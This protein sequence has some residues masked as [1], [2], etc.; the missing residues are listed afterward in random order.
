M[1]EVRSRLAGQPFSQSLHKLFEERRGAHAL[2]SRVM[3]FLSISRGGMDQR[4]E[5]DDQ[6]FNSNSGKDVGKACSKSAFDFAH[7]P[8]FGSARSR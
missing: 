2:P 6:G 1:E 4:A 5:L 7:P 8:I 3:V